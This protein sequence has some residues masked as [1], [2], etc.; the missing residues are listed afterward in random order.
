MARTSVGLRD[1]KG[2]VP[3]AFNIDDLVPPTPASPSSSQQLGSARAAA[4]TADSGLF[5]YND[6]F[7]GLFGWSQP[8]AS[9][10]ASSTQQP[11]APLSARDRAPPAE[12]AFG[13]QPSHGSSGRARSKGPS[14]SPDEREEMG[15]KA[16]SASGGSE[17]VVKQVRFSG[18]QSVP[19]NMA[20]G[21]PEPGGGMAQ[22]R[23]GH[24]L[25]RFTAPDDRYKCD[26][27]SRQVPRGSAMFGC[28]ICDYDECGDCVS[29]QA[30]RVQASTARCPRCDNFLEPSRA[31]E[32]MPCQ[33]SCRSKV[34]P[35][36]EVFGCY[37][38]RIGFCT[39]CAAEQVLQGPLN[40]QRSPTAG[41]S[42]LPLD[43]RF[44]RQAEND[45]RSR[46]TY[47]TE[48]YDV[49][50]QRLESQLDSFERKL[51]QRNEG[52]VKSYEEILRQA[53]I[54]EFIP[55]VSRSS[56]TRQRSETTESADPETYANM[57][58]HALRVAPASERQA[59]RKKIMVKWHPDKQGSQEA[60][61]FATRVMQ[62]ITSRPEWK[63]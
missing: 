20:A 54:N 2:S 53:G 31:N 18:S 41:S 30:M 43:G 38:C 27:C 47:G 29:W 56:S 60:S 45:D 50:Q 25:S 52:L 4:P 13:R 32:T 14:L 7:G 48:S 35:G 61:V 42:S 58:C 10:A 22:C 26:R 36:K 57:E 9:P 63:L 40:S 51:S 28:R 34:G 62:E 39:E 46:S 1:R 8:A 3:E 5:R 59:L 15:R 44:G 37:T 49:R 55:R 6:F 23:A 17:K 33:G 11:K 12:S 16:S 19:L 21:R 24:R